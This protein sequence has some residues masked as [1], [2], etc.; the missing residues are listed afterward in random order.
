MYSL[1]NAE[2]CN[3]ATVHNGTNETIIDANNITWTITPANNTICK[4][5]HADWNTHD[6]MLLVYWNQTIY[7]ENKNKYWW[8]W[9]TSS[10][11]WVNTANP[12]PSLNLTTESGCTLDVNT[13]IYGHLFNRK[14]SNNIN[15]FSIFSFT[16][17]WMVCAQRMYCNAA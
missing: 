17:F 9:D 11:S 1:A 5:G 3:G 15:S 16:S 13:G 10:S 2:S 12:R 7:Q 6:V 4:N 14:I 8:K